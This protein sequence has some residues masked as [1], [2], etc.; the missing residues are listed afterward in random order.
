MGKISFYTEDITFTLSQKRD[1]RAWISSIVAA[2]GKKVG[3]IS[4]I[5]CSDDYLLDVNKQ[6]LNHDYYTDI[7][8][9]DYCEGDVVS[10]D[11]F[12]SIPRVKEYALENSIDFKKELQRVVI[13]GVLHLLGQKDKKKEDAENMRKLEEKALKLFP[14]K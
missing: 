11:L 10:G 2:E 3:E 5:F 9:F 1:F 12:I 6:Y 7:I 14:K 8:T 4:Y 13:H